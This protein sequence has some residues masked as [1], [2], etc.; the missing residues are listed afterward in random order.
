MDPDPNAPR[1]EAGAPPANGAD[2][3]DAEATAEPVDDDTRPRSV[4]PEEVVGL[5]LLGWLAWVLVGLFSQPTRSDRIAAMDEPG[6]A[7]TRQLERPLE[8]A[9]VHLIDGGLSARFEDLFERTGDGPLGLDPTVLG[10]TAWWLASGAQDLLATAEL[11][12]E[13]DLDDM[14]A[15]LEDDAVEAAARSAIVAGAVGFEP[16]DLEVFQAFDGERAERLRAAIAVG[17]ELRDRAQ[18]AHDGESG[19]A[20]TDA[21]ADAAPGA[22]LDPQLDG[23]PQLLVQASRGTLPDVEQWSATEPARRSALG[24]T[25]QL[26]LLPLALVVAVALVVA[27]RRWRDGTPAMDARIA[28]RDGLGAFALCQLGIVALAYQFIAFDD[29]YSTGYSSL[30]VNLTT[31]LVALFVAGWRPARRGSCASALANLGLVATPRALCLGVA[32][33]VVFAPLLYTYGWGVGFVP[34]LHSD[35]WANPYASEEIAGGLPAW[36]RSAVEGAVWAPLFEE[37]IFR[38][39]LFAA[40]RGRMGFLPAALLSSGVF[41]MIHP[42]DL[43]GNLILVGGGV[44]FAWLYERTGNL[45]ACIAAHSAYNFAISIDSLLYL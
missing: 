33:G 21:P 9:A 2:E 38:G 41:A 31:P 17:A 24:R 8:G 10:D 25:I 28:T 37:I 36:W 26:W 43:V 44:A 14:A 29:P 20:R 16:P 1:P 13:Y 12:R 39:I 30:V 6:L 19:A 40:L 7:L 11:A 18:G 45:W 5:A 15:R 4:L 23:L 42:Y 32:T 35:L 3:R 27:P 34:A 22:T